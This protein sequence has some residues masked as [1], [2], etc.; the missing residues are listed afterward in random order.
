M[1]NVL[2]L[3]Q[4]ELIKKHAAEAERLGQLHPDVLQ[5]VIEEQW[6][7]LFVPKAYGGPG[8]K[9]PE[10]LRLEEALATVDGSL[11]WTVTLCSGAAWFAGFLDPELAKEVFSAPDV[12]FAGS[13]AVGGTA[14]STAN[15]YII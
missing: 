13:G 12:C 10:I 4:Q 8:K 5:M 14:R 11:A 1:E 6:F 3:A 15:G 2:T 9:L 7:K